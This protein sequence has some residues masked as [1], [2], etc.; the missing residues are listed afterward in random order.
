MPNTQIAGIRVRN[1]QRA[2]ENQAKH[3]CLQNM[4]RSLDTAVLTRSRARLT[5]LGPGVA[6]NFDF[7]HACDEE[8][9]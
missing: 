1:M 7:P 8:S 4:H 9:E 3:E 6:L 2:T 5:R